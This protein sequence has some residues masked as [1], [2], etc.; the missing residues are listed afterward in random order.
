LRTYYLFTGR[1]LH[2]LIVPNHK[3]VGPENSKRSVSSRFVPEVK[4]F[5]Q[6]EYATIELDESVP[7]VKLKLEGM[8]RSSDH[9]RQVQGKRLE[10][11]RREAG[12]HKL[13]HMLTD[14]RKAGPVLDEDV[15]YF[16][17]NVLTEMEDSGVRFLAIVRPTSLFTRLTVQEMTE[18]TRWLTVRGFDSVREAR[19][20]LKSKSPELL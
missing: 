12:R 3:L 2:I 7:C 18:K 4:L 19:E 10:L 9:Y 1:L 5:Y 16:R 11:L 15:D 17:L 8:P 14:S 13:L 20:W 6:D